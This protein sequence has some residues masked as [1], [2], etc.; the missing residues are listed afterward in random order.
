MNRAENWELILQLCKESQDDVIDCLRVELLNDFGKSDAFSQGPNF[1]H[2][3]ACLRSFLPR[4]K[5]GEIPAAAPHKPVIFFPATSGSN[6]LNLLPVAQEASR[7]NMLGGIVTGE[8]VARGNP[9]AFKEFSPVVSERML[10]ARLGIGFLAGS[11]R[12]AGW[13]L[14]RMIKWLQKRDAYYARRVRQN[15]GM[16]LR[17]MVNAERARIVCRELLSQ[18]QPSCILSTSDFYP[19][20][21]QFIWQA[22]K[23]G[24]PTSILQH[25]E[26]NDV[27]IWPTYAD[28]FLAWGESYREQLRSRGAPSDRVCVTG[29]PAGDTLFQRTLNKEPT[30][31]KSSAPVCLVLSHTQD[32]VEDSGLFEEFGRCLEE[33][34]QATPEME[35]KIKLHP[36]ED[37]SFYRERAIN[38]LKTVEIL[39]KDISLEQAVDQADVV[40]TIRSTAGLQAM[41]LQKPLIVLDLC[42]RG[43]SPVLWPLQ[44][45]GLYARNSVD[46]CKSL[47]CL[48]SE[49][50]FLSSLLNKQGG[51]LDLKFAHRGKAAAAI[52]DYLQEKT[53]PFRLTPLTKPK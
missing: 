32:R 11:L 27:V 42:K 19:F 1:R 18:W 36:S 21:F 3:A 33:T 28:T 6:L 43:G 16:Y 12:R 26:T 37:D 45:G 44:G 47:R 46:F 48:C 9:G 30:S 17:L 29:M 40:C 25:G 35:W 7:R 53:A 52:V 51:F 8:A 49:Y 41:M 10:N 34:I 13:R 50:D 24:I 39:S 14:R 20:E 15:Y 5:A 38:G 4:S 22:R 2:L 31:K 23:L